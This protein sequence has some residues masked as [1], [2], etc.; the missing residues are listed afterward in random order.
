MRKYDTMDHNSFKLS[1]DE[2][3]PHGAVLK[4][5]KKYKSYKTEPLVLEFY[6]NYDDPQTGENVRIYKFNKDLYEKCVE[7]ESAAVAKT[8]KIQIE[9]GKKLSKYDRKKK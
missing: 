7:K 8:R 5:L 9:L 3:L 6:S 2:G 4:K 1:T